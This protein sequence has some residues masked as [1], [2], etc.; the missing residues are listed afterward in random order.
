MTY[1]VT[2]RVARI[3]LDRPERGNG[4]TAELIAELV[5]CVEAADLDPDRPRA[6]AVGAT[7]RASAAAT[8]SSPAPRG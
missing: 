8:T 1:E 5:R 2:G 7:A 6:A 3:T 4:L